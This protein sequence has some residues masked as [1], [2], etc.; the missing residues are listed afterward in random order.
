[1][2]LRVLGTVG[3]AV[4]VIVV[5]V[6]VLVVRAHRQVDGWCGEQD[7]AALERQFGSFAGGLTVESEIG[8]WPP[9]MRCR[10]SDGAD[11]VVVVRRSIF[12]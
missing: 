5:V 9:E 3:L 8:Y 7:R 6:G 4:A 11:R 2:R 10:F 12:G 1:V